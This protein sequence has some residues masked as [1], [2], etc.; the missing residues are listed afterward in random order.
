MLF[1]SSIYRYGQIAY[2][3]GGFGAGIHNLP[4]AAVYGIPV[5]FGPNYKKFLEAK[6]LIKQ[7]GGFTISN[8]KELNKVLKDFVTSPEDLEIAGDAAT[9][10][11]YKSAGATDKIV[12]KIAF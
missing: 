4:E 8:E 9:N 11:I 10:Y 6:E 1:R 7:G 2:I 3:G 12:D 5:I